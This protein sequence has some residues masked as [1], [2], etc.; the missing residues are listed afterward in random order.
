MRGD[1]LIIDLHEPIRLYRIH[2]RGRYYVLL[3]M[4]TNP[5]WIFGKLQVVVLRLH[6]S[7]EKLLKLAKMLLFRL[8]IL[9]LVLYLPRHI[10]TANND[11]LKVLRWYISHFGKLV[12]QANQLDRISQERIFVH[13]LPIFIVSRIINGSDIYSL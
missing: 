1:I 12:D 2:C 3:E 8:T 5:F 7:I 11:L 9:V 10:V 6:F 4:F 13:F